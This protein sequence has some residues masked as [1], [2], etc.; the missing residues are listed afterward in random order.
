MAID[1]ISGESHSPFSARALP[2]QVLSTRRGGAVAPPWPVPPS[3]TRPG[4]SPG[5]DEQGAGVG[6]DVARTDAAVAVARRL[7]SRRVAFWSRFLRLLRS[8][9]LRPDFRITDAIQQ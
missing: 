3:M 4:D 6:R 5:A 2:N 1:S 9:A 7:Q 8:D